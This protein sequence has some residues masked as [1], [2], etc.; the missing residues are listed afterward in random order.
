MTLGVTRDILERI[1][2]RYP[3]T[4]TRTRA[5]QRTCGIE[6]ITPLYA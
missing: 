5:A 6:M 4:D 1:Q 2:L 3:W